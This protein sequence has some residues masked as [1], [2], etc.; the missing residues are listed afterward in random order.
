MAARVAINGFGRIGRL[1]L[2]AIYERKCEDVEIVAINDL[3]PVADLGEHS[4]RARSQ[5]LGN[6]PAGDK[7]HSAKL[8][9]LAAERY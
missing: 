7:G 2:H 9:P 8:R 4:G 5:F 1:V 6:R 3:G